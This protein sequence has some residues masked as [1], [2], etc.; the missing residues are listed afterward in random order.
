MPSACQVGVAPGGTTR[1]TLILNFSLQDMSSE[2][3]GLSRGLC[4]LLW[5]QRL[6]VQVRAPSTLLSTGSAR[7]DAD[8]G[9]RLPRT[10]F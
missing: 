4:G 6:I 9:V 7:R 3:P 2:L 5:A 1:D 8:T 10:D